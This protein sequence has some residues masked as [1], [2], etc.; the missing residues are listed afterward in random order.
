VASEYI[1]RPRPGYALHEAVENPTWENAVIEEH[2][3]GKV[4]AIYPVTPFTLNAFNPIPPPEYYRMEKERIS[5]ITLR[6]IIP[7]GY[8]ASGV[9]PFIQAVVSVVSRAGVAEFPEIYKGVVEGF[10][11]LPDTKA[12]QRMLKA[13]VK[14]MSGRPS[15]LTVY[16]EG[17]RKFY[18]EG[19]SLKL[20]PPLVKRQ[21]GVDPIDAAVCDFGEGESLFSYP[22][23]RSYVVERLRWL[24]SD[25]YLKDR[26]DRLVK[27][28]YLEK[29][30]ELY[31]FKR[32]VDRFL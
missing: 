32:R 17:R 12:S 1:I 2:R 15:F 3:Y 14:W 4:E 29:R 26:V 10:R 20:Q 23:V 28:G 6:K 9:S 30:G 21:E 22:Q 13:L 5:G 25:E 24:S 19:V 18:R 31:L 8:F 7:D 16:K 11:I 27:G